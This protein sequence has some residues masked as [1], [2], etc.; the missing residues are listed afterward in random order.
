MSNGTGS[1]QPGSR[2]SGVALLGVAAAVFIVCS[3]IQAACGSSMFASSYVDSGNALKGLLIN[4][5]FWPGWVL[6]GAFAV[7]GGA[8]LLKSR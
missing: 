4:L 2:G 6:T 8:E 3:I 1:G 7:R 5:T